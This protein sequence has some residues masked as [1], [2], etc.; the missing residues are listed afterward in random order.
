MSPVAIFVHVFL[1]FVSLLWVSVI[2]DSAV[3]YYVRYS[4]PFPP[5]ISSDSF[6]FPPLKLVHFISST[7]V[8]RIIQGESA[9]DETFFRCAA[10]NSLLKNPG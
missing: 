7:L 4:V 3:K 5:T 6:L 10:Q 9:V 1:A 8:R 2:K